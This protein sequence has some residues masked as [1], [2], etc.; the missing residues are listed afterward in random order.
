MN[1]VDPGHV[2]DQW[3]LGSDEHQRITFV[4]RSGGAIQYDDEHPGV[5]V[6]EVLRVLIDRSKYLD[7]II[8][9]AETEDAIYHLRMALFMYEVRAYRRKREHVNRYAPQHDDSARPR[10]WRE[11]PFDDIPFNEHEIE[12][13]PRGADGHI[14]VEDF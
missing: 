4:K 7:D 3:Q 11:L 14:I 1:V 13:R 10:P 6:Q 9:C 2:Y 12:L 8:P 5:Q